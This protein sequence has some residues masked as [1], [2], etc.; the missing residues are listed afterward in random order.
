LCSISNSYL[1]IENDSG[2]VGIGVT[3]PDVELVV[4]GTLMAVNLPSNLVTDTDKAVLNE[5][6]VTQFL[7]L[8]SGQLLGEDLIVHGSLSLESLLLE[9]YFDSSLVHLDLV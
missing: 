2:N 3:N 8:S 6:D 5:L 4:D 1:S 9:S 7:N